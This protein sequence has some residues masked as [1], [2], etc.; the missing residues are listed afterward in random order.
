VTLHRNPPALDRRQAYTDRDGEYGAGGER[1]KPLEASQVVLFAHSQS[2][3]TRF[4]RGEIERARIPLEDVR[5]DP[6]TA[7]GHA[8]EL[9]AGRSDRYV[10]HLDVEVVD[11]TDAPLSEHP[12]R[13]T[14]LS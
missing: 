10:I 5:N 11:F 4:E 6:E 8:L 9:L 13:N 3:A 7:A 12:S 14:G 2:N 1:D